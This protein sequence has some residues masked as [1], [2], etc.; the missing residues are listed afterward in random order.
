MLFLDVYAAHFNLTCLEMFTGNCH[1]FQK[2]ESR[3]LSV[4]LRFFVNWDGTEM[5]QLLQ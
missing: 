1:I 4:V 3:F 2:I 5:N